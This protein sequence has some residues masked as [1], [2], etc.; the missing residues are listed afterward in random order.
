MVSDPNLKS[1]VK[2]LTPTFETEFDR[3]TGIRKSFIPR[4]VAE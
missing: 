2:K 4:K 3:D 1:P